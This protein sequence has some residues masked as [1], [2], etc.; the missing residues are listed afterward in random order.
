MQVQHFLSAVEASGGIYTHRWGDAPI[1]T[2]ALRLFAPPATVA[3]VPTDYLHV[4]TMNRIYDDGHET[5]GWFDGEMRRHPI[6]RAHFRRQ[7]S[8]TNLTHTTNCSSINGSANV[9]A[10]ASANTSANA[11]ASAHCPLAVD[12]EQASSP[13]LRAV[14]F[15]SFPTNS[16][17][18]YLSSDKLGEIASAFASFF[19]VDPPAVA[20]KKDLT[21]AGATLDLQVLNKESRVVG[22]RESIV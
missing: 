13:A 18:S 1:Q 17:W 5:D 3:R 8:A 2:L 19:S 9:S 15:L 14:V 12:P 6:V 10:N 21:S 22:E 11:S 4:S 20:V 7:L 16:S